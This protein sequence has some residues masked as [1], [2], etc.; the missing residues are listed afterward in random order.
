M[1]VKAVPSAALRNAEKIGKTIKLRAT[2]RGYYG[3]RGTIAD[4]R[5]PGQVFDFAV[6][7][8]EPATKKQSGRDVITVDGEKYLL[9]SWVE[10]AS[11]EPAS[12]ED[13]DAEVGAGEGKG[14]GDEDVL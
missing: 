5:E 13:D 12:S 9:P 2:Q 8:L 10:D 1:A 14:S 4:I 3:L 11:K 6:K 7:D